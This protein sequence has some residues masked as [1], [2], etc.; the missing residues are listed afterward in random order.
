M[1][2]GEN[3]NQWKLLINLALQP[4]DVTARESNSTLLDLDGFRV[5]LLLNIHIVI[6]P[7]LFRRIEDRINGL[8][9]IIHKS[10]GSVS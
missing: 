5:Y 2:T 3:A 9:V 10:F 4:S 6:L 1:K 8:Y 7:V